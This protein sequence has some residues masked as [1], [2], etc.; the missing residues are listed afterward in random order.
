VV[1]PVSWSFPAPALVE[2]LVG[3]DDALLPC[4]VGVALV[5]VKVVAV[6]EVRSGRSQCVVVVVVVVVRAVV[7]VVESQ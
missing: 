5:M 7:G 3:D 1:V 4:R 2:I 6:P